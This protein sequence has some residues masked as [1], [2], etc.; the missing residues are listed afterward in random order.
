MYN[1][2]NKY[3]VKMCCR[4]SPKDCVAHKECIWDKVY[5]E[6]TTS[7]VLPER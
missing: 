7:P 5:K 6:C 2:C 4:T 3:I 1:I